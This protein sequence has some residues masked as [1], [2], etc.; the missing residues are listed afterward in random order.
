[1]KP[2]YIET[3]YS[4]TSRRVLRLSVWKCQLYSSC[5]NYV[6][7]PVSGQ[8]Q[9]QLYRPCTRSLHIQLE[10]YIGD[11]FSSQHDIICEASARQFVRTKS[12]YNGSPTGVACRFPEC[13]VRLLPTCHIYAFYISYLSPICTQFIAVSRKFFL[14]Q[15]DLP[16]LAMCIFA[17]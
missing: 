12:E 16:P 13:T 11:Q 15:G 1:M 14:E 6:I 17:Q 2:M 10:L 4:P 7:R 9:L 5:G 3:V 8:I